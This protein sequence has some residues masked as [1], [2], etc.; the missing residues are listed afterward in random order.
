[1]KRIFC[2]LLLIFVSQQGFSQIS[3]EE[4]FKQLRKIRPPNDSLPS[5]DNGSTTV[6]INGKTKYTDFKVISLSKDTTY[7]DTTLNIQKHYMFN[8]RRKD[9]FEL[10]PFHNIGQTFNSLAYRFDRVKLQPDLGFRA[11][12][13]FYL[14]VDEIDYYD[15]ATPTSEIMFMTTLEQ[16]QFL[17]SFF[18]LNFSKRL[19]ASIAYTGL[20]SLGKYR[21][22]LVSQGNFRTTFRYESKE[23]Q[24]TLKGH[25]ASQDLLNEE[26]GGLTATSLEAFETNDE[27]FTDRARMDV[28]L[29]NT[30]SSLKGTRVY[31]RHDYKLLASKDTSHQKN[32]SNLK[33][34]HV[35]LPRRRLMNSDKIIPQYF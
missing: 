15:V 25:I 28:N 1:M 20:R 7:I 19:N 32:F 33:M 5:V 16:G 23:G 29:D 9:H 13:F 27:N 6:V 14:D 18:T 34:G 3:K 31:V 26:S 8:F 35:F 22:S 4:K 2:F 11:K 10:L 24:Y 30:E 17:E 21:Q 12:Q